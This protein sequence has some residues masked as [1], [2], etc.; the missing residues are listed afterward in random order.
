MLLLSELGGIQNPYTDKRQ[1]VSFNKSYLAW[2]ANMSWRKLKRQPYQ[3]NGAAE[4]GE[5]APEVTPPASIP[6][7]E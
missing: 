6:P 7:A 5:A 3:I 2:K 4:R 1:V